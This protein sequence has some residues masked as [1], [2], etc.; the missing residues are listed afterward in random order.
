MLRIPVCL[1]VFF[2]LAAPASAQILPGSGPPPQPYQANDGGGFRDILPPGTRG[3]YNAVEL[4]AFLANGTTVP[5]CCDQLG[6]Y[7]DLV[8]ATPGLEADDVPGQ[9]QLGAEPRRLREC[10]LGEVGAAEALGEPQVVLDRRAL[11]R[12]ATGRLALHDDGAQAGDVVRSATFSPT[13]PAK[14][15]VSSRKGP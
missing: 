15:P 9:H 13:G 7:R 12:L 5:H 8:Y 3:H 1:A 11:A 10:A 4:A 14:T 2:V 6:M